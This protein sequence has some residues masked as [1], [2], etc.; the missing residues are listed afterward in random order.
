[1]RGKVGREPH[2]RVEP[3]IRPKT[4]KGVCLGTPPGHD[5]IVERN[6]GKGNKKENNLSM[7]HVFIDQSIQKST[8]KENTI[9]E[10]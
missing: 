7:Y 3:G 5:S 4:G 2:S 1:M 10:L 9:C 6:E 8:G